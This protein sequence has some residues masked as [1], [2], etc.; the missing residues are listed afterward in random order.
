MNFSE[1]RERFRAVLAGD[2]CVC[3]APVHDAVSA[4][5]ADDLGF[6]IGILP[7][8][9]AQAALLAAPNHHMV[10]LTLS[11][12]ADHVRHICQA[13]DLSLYVGGY[14][15]FGNALNVMRT[16]QE[17]EMAGASCLTIDDNM[18][19]APFGT[20]ITGWVGH[21]SFVDETLVPLDEMVGRVK[22]ALAARRDPTLVIA[23][24]ASA[25]L[26]CSIP[27]AIRRVKAY[28]KAGVDTVHIEW[29]S[30][31]GIAAIH[32][33]TRLPLM[34]GQNGDRLD[35]QF[36]AEHGVRIGQRGNLTFRASIKAIY[37]CLKA[38]RE[39][40]TP[41]DLAP[42]IISPELFARATRQEQFNHWF[43]DFLT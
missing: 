14:H 38:L 8:P 22:A 29:P 40:K 25:L 2:Q 3:P 43:K 37:D 27:E 6:E 30:A 35:N 23:V 9:I 39:G 34:V 41:A 24:H 1:R 5:I 21:R 11:E 10:T 16:V 20:K 26:A 12:M 33:E 42:M 17:L 31:E 13:S 4:V 36:L 7:G 15:G 28:E 19:P 32:A 18:E